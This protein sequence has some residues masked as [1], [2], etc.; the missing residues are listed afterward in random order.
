MA[1][2]WNE[3]SN[4]EGKPQAEKIPDGVHDLT[5]K[6]IVYGSK[7]KDFRS[8]SGDTQMMVVFV[9]AE[10]CEAAQMYTLSQKA[11]WTLARLLGA[12]G[13]DLAR[14]KAEGVEPVNFSDPDFAETNLL[15]RTLRAEVKWVEKGGKVHSEVTPIR[16]KPVSDDIPF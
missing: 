15:N 14:M 12:C 16:K 9:D 1:Y 13:L 10:G 5:V 7:A 4:R 2:D 8:K 11:A 3:E 6:K